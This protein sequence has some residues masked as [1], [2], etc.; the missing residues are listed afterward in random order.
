MSD[1]QKL[2]LIGLDGATFRVLRPLIE[3]GVMPT[4]AKMVREGASGPLMSTHP[5]VTC[6]AWPTM[7]T[8]VNPGKHGVFSFTCRGGDRPH[9]A[10]LVDVKSPTMWE[11]LSAG[12][13]R[14]AVLNVPITYPAQQ[15]NGVMLSGFPA[16]DGT[17]EV[18]WPRERHADLIRALPQYRVNWP[19]I[20]HAHAPDEQAGDVVRAAND[21]LR[22]RIES[23]DH[24]RYFIPENVLNPT[25]FDTHLY[26]I[27]KFPNFRI[28][29]SIMN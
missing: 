18:V 16:P 11:L 17:A 24:G 25:G 21:W 8:G 4:V 6:P 1:S 28:L 29:D 20:P 14:C 3:A 15:L 13:R 12:G 9:T 7:Y 23:F 2:V 5:P 22:E 19:G 26:Y 10:S 27:V